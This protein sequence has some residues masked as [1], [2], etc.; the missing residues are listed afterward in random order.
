MTQCKVVELTYCLHLQSEG[1]NNF[2]T[3]RV[4]TCLNKWLYIPEER[5]QNIQVCEN[6]KP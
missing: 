2:L 3:N 1:G 6:L 5:N 4:S